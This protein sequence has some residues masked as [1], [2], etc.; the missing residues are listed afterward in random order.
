VACSLS[1][2]LSLLSRRLSCMMR[3]QRYQQ[4][5]K[6]EWGPMSSIMGHLGTTQRMCW[7]SG[8][9]CQ[10]SQF[11]Y[12]SS[13]TA[14]YAC[15][16]GNAT[17]SVARESEGPCLLSWAIWAQ[18]SVCWCSGSLW[19]LSLLW[20]PPCLGRMAV[21][22]R[23]STYRSAGLSRAIGCGDASYPDGPSGGPM[24]WALQLCLGAHSL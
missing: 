18:H 24:R 7:C 15:R 20:Q 8:S 17:S 1:L 12:W 3:R 10:L 2:S 11:L 4:R 5:G 19:Q 21:L 22:P 9:L 23:S 14:S 6:G 16:G 13:P